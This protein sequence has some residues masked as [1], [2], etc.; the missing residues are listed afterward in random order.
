MKITD[1]IRMAQAKIANLG[2]QRT[3]AE[4]LGDVERVNRIDGEIAETQTT[5]A[6]LQTLA[7]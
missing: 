6:Q 3:S 1:L 7:E 4:R 2:A 5:L